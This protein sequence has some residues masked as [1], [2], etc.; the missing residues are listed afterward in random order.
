MA[1]RHHRIR[2]PVGGFGNGT[3]NTPSLIEAAS[4]PPFFHNNLTDTIEGA[5]AFYNTS[6]FNLSRA[7]LSFLG[8]ISLDDE[9]VNQ[10]AAFLRVINALEKIRSAKVRRARLF[11]LRGLRGKAAR[12]KEIERA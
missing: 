2:N 7:A 12:L 11:Y 8:P 9:E 3:F 1:V 6:S 4:S 5:V 10:V